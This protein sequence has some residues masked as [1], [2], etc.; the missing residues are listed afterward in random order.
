[1]L[2]GI[3][4]SLYYMIFENKY[5]DYGLVMGFYYA[6]IGFPVIMIVF[7]VYY[8][9]FSWLE[10]RQIELSFFKKLMVT[11]ITTLLYF[12]IFLVCNPEASLNRWMENLISSLLFCSFLALIYEMA[13]KIISRYD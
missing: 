7:S 10:K 6:L 13:A 8:F 12:A 11:F 2:G 4:L 5:P 9:Q 3:L 1:V